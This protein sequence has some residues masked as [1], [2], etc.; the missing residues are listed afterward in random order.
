MFVVM[1][2]SSAFAEKDQKFDWDHVDK[3]V[4]DFAYVNPDVSLSKY[5]EVYISDPKV[6]FDDTWLNEYR[7]ASKTYRKR[8]KKAYGENFKEALIKAI[9]KKTKFKVVSKKTADTL[10]IIPKI[11]KLDI[12]TPDL[13]GHKESLVK[14]AGFAVADVTVFSPKDKAVAALFVDKRNT[15][16]FTSSEAISKIRNSNERSFAKLFGKWSKNIAEAVSK[17]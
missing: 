12:K 8:I 14:F 17:I 3:G 1:V 9:E 2:C 15:P 6:S 10:V 16:P 11:E 5:T 7:E 4:F 13:S